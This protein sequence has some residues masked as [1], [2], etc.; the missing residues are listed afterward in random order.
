M[1]LDSQYVRPYLE[2]VAVDE[3]R[4]GLLDISHCRRGQQLSDDGQGL[5]PM[6]LLPASPSASSYACIDTII[7]YTANGLTGFA[8]NAEHM[9]GALACANLMTLLV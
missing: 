6:P 9:K 4:D 3:Q 2:L 1:R 5:L 8:G 7:A